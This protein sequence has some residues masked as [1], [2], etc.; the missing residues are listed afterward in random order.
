MLALL[1]V[2]PCV[3]VLPPGCTH[4]CG[5]YHVKSRLLTYIVTSC[6]GNNSLPG[7]RLS[8]VQGKS[9]VLILTNRKWIKRPNSCVSLLRNVSLIRAS[10]GAGC[11]DPWLPEP[12]QDMTSTLTSL[13]YFP[14]RLAFRMHLIFVN[15]LPLRAWKR[16]GWGRETRGGSRELLV[17]LWEPQRIC[18]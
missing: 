3:S 5:R 15:K 6:S 4:T 7:F 14:R 17:R 11:P 18:L 12:G 16:T 10:L 13:V 1:P 9:T 2:D 8:H